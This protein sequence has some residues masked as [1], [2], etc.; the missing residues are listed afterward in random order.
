M[1]K[2][3]VSYRIPRNLLVLLN[4][5]ALLLLFVYEKD[6]LDKFTTVSA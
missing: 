4:L 3:L 1:F 5:M 6:N 2:K